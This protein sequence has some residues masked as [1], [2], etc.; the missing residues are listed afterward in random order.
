MG[1][2]SEQ[3]IA[4]SFPVTVRG[5]DRR[6]TAFAVTTRTTDI[7]F[8]G[9]ALKGLSGV[10]AAGA[11]AEIECH[12]QKAWYR[13]Q[14][15]TQ[16]QSSSAGGV[17]LRCLE[18]GKYIWGLPPK[19]WEADTWDPAN[20]NHSA[21]LPDTAISTY[22]GPPEWSSADRRQ[23]ARHVCRIKAEVYVENDSVEMPG[24]ITDISLGGCYLQMLSPL[25]V[26]MTIRVG[27][28]P[29]DTTLNLTGKVHSSQTGFGMGVSFTGMS[30]GDFENLRK[31]APPA[32]DGPVI[33]PAKTP[34]NRPAEARPVAPPVNARSYGAGD[35]ALDWTPTREALE[36]LVRLLLRKEIVTQGELAEELEKLKT[37]ER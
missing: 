35:D 8:S 10:V 34:P 13:V 3:R 5:T 7:S 36:A 28:N 22:A 29:G 19:E 31:F 18:I 2:R 14:W 37:I 25:P 32:S 33:A 23:F 6:G 11:K 27:L 12:D 1:R 24:Q 16:G 20:R 9:A 30:P 21:P 15:V 4:I 17:G 26:G